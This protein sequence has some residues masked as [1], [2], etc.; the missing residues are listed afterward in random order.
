MYNREKIIDILR[1]IEKGLPS[2]QKIKPYVVIAQP[3]RDLKETPAQN[4]DGVPFHIDLLGYSHGFC[5]CGGEKVD[6][7]RNYLIEQV[8]ESGAKYMFFVGEDTVIPYDGFIKL[9]ETAEQNPD[10]MVVG[11][12]YIKLSSPMLHI[13]SGDYIIPT[14]VSPGQVFP[15]IGCGLDAALIPVKLLQDIKADDPEIPFCVTAMGIMDGEHELPFVGEDNFFLYRWMKRGHRVLCNTDVQC[16]HMDL[17]T[18]KYTAHPSVQPP[19][20]N[21]C[22]NIPITTPL[23]MEDRKFIE[24][25]WLDRLPD[26]SYGIPV[27]TQ[28][29]EEID[30]CL[31]YVKGKKLILEIGTDM[32]GTLYKFIHVAD[33]SAEIVAID[34]SGGFGSNGQPDESVFQG[35]KLPNQTLH[36]IR[37]NS[38][39]PETLEQ[40]KKILNGRKFDFAFIDGDHIYEGVKAD[41]D[42]YCDC[43]EIMAFHDIAAQPTNKVVGVK[44]FWDELKGD[45]TEFIKDPAQGWGGIGILNQTEPQ[46][47]IHG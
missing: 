10:S 35:W 41:Y 33:P 38:H 28:V 9:H 30:K 17:A 31:E 29:Q 25:R 24:R 11:V 3:R 32:G 5:N 2:M 1:G 42:M 44:R 16:L 6:V 13:R 23:T 15:V 14:D 20:N 39:L 19:F 43:C 36:I 40:V 45:K 8:L 27:A 12:Y 22:T 7:A 4:L 47:V 26:G 18:G 34:W 21:Y 37:A 46:E